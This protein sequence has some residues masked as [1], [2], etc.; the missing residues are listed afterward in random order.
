VFERL[1][2]IQFMPADTIGKR[3]V[4]IGLDDQGKHSGSR[5]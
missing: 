4:V 3:P 1:I 5:S 2:E